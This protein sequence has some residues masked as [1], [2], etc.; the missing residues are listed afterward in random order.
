MPV[1]EPSSSTRSQVEVPAETTRP[2]SRVAFS[3]SGTDLPAHED[4]RAADR[5]DSEVRG[6]SCNVSSAKSPPGPF[7]SSSGG[8]DAEISTSRRRETNAKS[9][10]V[11]RELPRPPARRAS[12]RVAGFRGRRSH[13]PLRGDRVEVVGSRSATAW[14]DALEARSAPRPPPRSDFLKTTNAG[15]RVEPGVDDTTNRP[16]ERIEQDLPRGG[17]C[18][19]PTRLTPRVPRC[20][21]DSGFDSFAAGHLVAARSWSRRPFRRF[22]E[23]DELVAPASSRQSAGFPPARGS[24]RRGGTSR[25]GESGTRR[26]GTSAGSSTIPARQRQRAA[27]DRE[28]E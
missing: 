6:V 26:C 28:E 4:R 3:G 25:S 11:P 9:P 7:A 22:A 27:P 13:G 14:A 20:D 12:A 21:S 2:S 16:R 19:L 17:T 10:P 8:S 24:P 15:A 23:L 1:C 18:L 5:Q